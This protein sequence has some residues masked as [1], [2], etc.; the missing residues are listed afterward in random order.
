MNGIKMAGS[1]ASAGLSLVLVLSVEP[2]RKRFSKLFAFSKRCLPIVE[3]TITGHCSIGVHAVKLRNLQDASCG[4]CLEKDKV[5][6][7]QHFLLD[8]LAFVGS[9]VKHSGAQTF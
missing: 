1:M 9:R 4:C 3:G 8:C 2:N 5:E 7:S 6:T